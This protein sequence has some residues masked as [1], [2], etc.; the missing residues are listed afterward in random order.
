MEWNAS[1]HFFLG[2]KNCLTGCCWSGL[3]VN[4]SRSCGHR[5]S[6]RREG[7]WNGGNGR[8]GR[9]DGR[10]D[11]LILRLVLCHYKWTVTGSW[12]QCSSSRTSEFSWRRRKGWLKKITVSIS[13]WFQLT[14]HNGLLLSCPCLQIIYFVFL[15]KKKKDICTFLI[16]SARAMYQCTA[17]NLNHCGILTTILFKIR[18]LVLAITRWEVKKQPFCGEWE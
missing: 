15:N 8:N 12:R 1:F 11:V 13:Y 10:R 16:L 4:Y 7:P 18:I 17:F 5:N 14:I 9:G 6:E 3:S 2:C